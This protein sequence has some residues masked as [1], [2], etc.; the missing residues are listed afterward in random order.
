MR[1][2]NEK[3]IFLNKEPDLN[4]IAG[5]CD[6]KTYFCLYENREEITIGMG[7][8]IDIYVTPTEIIIRSGG[9]ENKVVIKDICN[10][11]EKALSQID[12][13]GWRLYGTVNF[14]LARY[15]YGFD[16]AKE[17]E[18]LFHFFIPETEYRITKKTVLLR[19]IEKEK[20]IE[21]EEKLWRKFS[22][23]KKSDKVTFIDSDTVIRY[24]EDYYKSIVAAGVEEIRDGKYQKVIL[25]RKI[26]I[27][28]RLDMRET[29][30]RGRRVNTPQ[31]SYWC[32]MGTLEVAGFSPEIVAEVDRERN[33]YTFP[34]AGTRALTNN[35]ENNE[36]L[37]NDLLHDTKEIAEHAVSVK[38]ASD[39]MCQ[40][41]EKNSVAVTEFMSVMERGTVQHL[42]S[43]LKGKLKKELNSWH[44][45]CKLF[46]AVTASGIPKKEAIEAIGRIEKE[47]R[48]LYSGSV[49]TYN[50]DGSFDA[51]LVLR[52]IFQTN[53]ESWVRVGAGIVD[54]S[55]PEREFTETQE[56][57]SSV[58]NQ[59]IQNEE[60]VEI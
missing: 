34:L 36:T 43:R 10:D 28:V 37:R 31:R 20:L 38:L 2:Y 45:L 13:D 35:P 46:P 52:S 40:I 24:D 56:K 12:L 22:D 51:A 18:E 60:S 59:L 32:R 54:M 33:V 25:S 11:M 50:S 57:V 47:A 39:E 15:T 26:P 8:Y 55:N 21:L 7:E 58:A 5:L 17:G 4:E 1:S 16:C 53:R 41:C 29:Y 6:D 14:S 48:G 3:K 44:A 19:A 23:E 42:G 49:M 30:I 9:K 27:E